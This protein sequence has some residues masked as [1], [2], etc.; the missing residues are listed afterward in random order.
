LGKINGQ[1]SGLST[2][3]LYLTYTDLSKMTKKLDPKEVAC[4]PKG[5]HAVIDVCPN[6]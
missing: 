1:V 2:P 3:P 4:C 5:G 6:Q